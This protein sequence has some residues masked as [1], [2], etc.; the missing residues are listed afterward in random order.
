MPTVVAAI[1][2]AKPDHE[3]LPSSDLNADVAVVL[4]VLT[5]TLA[6]PAG[7]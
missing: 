6:S 5:E 1:A 2:T 4:S 7:T 3:D